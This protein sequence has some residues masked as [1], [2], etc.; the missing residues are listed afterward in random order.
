MTR[1]PGTHLSADEIDS[2]LS[3]NLSQEWQQHLDH[4]QACLERVRVEREIVDQIAALPL[5][6]PS[7]GFSERVM[8]SVS[9]PDPF[10]IRSLQATQRRLFATRRSV[11]LA[12]SLTILLLG[13]M[14]G[15]IA[16]SLSHQD[17]LAS[18]GD[19]LLAQGGQI[20]WLSLRGVASNLMEQPWYGTARSLL[21]NPI[22]LAAGS[23]LAT[24]VY[25]FGVLALR[26]LLALPNQQV[27][28]AA[29]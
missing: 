19:W 5:M 3:G 20:A 9:I 17:T 26:R 14:A 7:G 28:H 2:W 4:C 18:I 24:T 29:I 13:S 27:A 10:A 1:P 12:A 11:A 25:L 16:W 8:A 22:H 23:A 21:G 6:S 15:S